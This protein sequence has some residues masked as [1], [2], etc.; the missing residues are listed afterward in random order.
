M[1]QNQTLRERNRS[2][3]SLGVDVVLTATASDHVKDSPNGE[4]DADDPA[5]PLV[6]LGEGQRST[7]D[8]E[9]RLDPQGV[10]ESAVLHEVLLFDQDGKEE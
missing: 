4:A 3:S 10:H 9:Q 1:R 2:T 6:E 7:E 8:V 5:D